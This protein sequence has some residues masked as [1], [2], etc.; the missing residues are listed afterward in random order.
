MS[1][2][3]VLPQSSRE[4]VAFITSG[5]WKEPLHCARAE[6]KR[7]GQIVKSVLAGAGLKQLGEHLMEDF[8]PGDVF[9][10]IKSSFYLRI[11]C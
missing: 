7:I 8:K 11:T 1:D 9:K 2:G 10:A 6:N 5:E 4:E 3:G